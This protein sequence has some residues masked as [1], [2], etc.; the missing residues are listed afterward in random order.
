MRGS[1][2]AR[3]AA[4]M[5]AGSR[6]QRLPTAPQQ[7][8]PAS[9]ADGIVAGVTVRFWQAGNRDRPFTGALPIPSFSPVF[10]SRYPSGWGDRVRRS[11]GCGR[12]LAARLLLVVAVMASPAV[13]S[14]AAAARAD[15]S[16]RLAALLATGGAVTIPPGDYRLDGTAPTLGTEYQHAGD[17]RDHNARWPHP[18]PHV[19]RHHL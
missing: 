12:R 1:E 9:A 3:N 2:S 6:E 14:P 15:D 18:K 13:A 4:A 10:D 17:S 7:R 8:P 19:S 11:A 16:P 5:P